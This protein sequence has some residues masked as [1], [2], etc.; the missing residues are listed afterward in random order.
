MAGCLLIPTYP[1]HYSEL[2]RNLRSLRRHATDAQLPHAFIVFDRIVDVEQQQQRQHSFE[3]LWS[4]SEFLH[5]LSL[6][7]LMRAA[8]EDARQD[9]A[10]LS[11]MEEARRQHCSKGSAASKVSH[12][13]ADFAKS[14]AFKASCIKRC[15]TGM[16]PP[17]STLP[18][19]PSNATATQRFNRYAA[20][21]NAAR[22]G[23]MSGS[24]KKAANWP[25]MSASDCASDRT[26]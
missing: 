17:L 24:N 9:S 12:L 5:S 8:G 13:C 19:L 21:Q 14:D 25:Q 26:R 22:R 6:E 15:V 1:D 16:Q 7:A 23:T 2:E 11:L 4:P 18:P 10:V 3:S 20:S